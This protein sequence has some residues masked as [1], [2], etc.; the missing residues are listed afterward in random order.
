MFGQSDSYGKYIRKRTGF[1]T[2]NQA[3]KKTCKNEHQHQACAGS[4]HGQRRS[5]QA[6]RYTGA[7]IS[8]VLKAYA[9]SCNSEFEMPDQTL[10]MSEIKWPSNTDGSSC[11]TQV[12]QKLQMR[13]DQPVFHDVLP[14]PHDEATAV[15][16]DPTQV[17]MQEIETNVCEAFPVHE[18]PSAIAE[19]SPHPA[20]RRRKQSGSNVVTSPEKA[21]IT[22]IEKAH[23]GMGHPRHSRFLRILKMGRATPAA[24]GL[25]KTFEC[26]QCKESTR[27][28][29]W[30]RAAPPRELSFNEVVG[31][32]TVTI[33][34]FD[35]NIKCL[36][37]ICWGTGISLSCH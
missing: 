32:D 34:H 2:N 3:L 15:V 16:L 19:M 13:N 11:P 37:I 14:Q 4:S 22:E 36:N 27:P 1:M 6:A 18:S 33:K 5:T 21:L 35:H 8:A 31:I 24:L 10:L 28:K 20:L 7:L 25:A 9:R 30:R 23:T 17:Y 29:P 26:S 12:T